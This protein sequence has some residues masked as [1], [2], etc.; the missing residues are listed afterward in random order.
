MADEWKEYFENGLG[1]LKNEI[2]HQFHVI[3]EDV[4]SKVQQVADGVINLDGK[5]DRRADELD[6]KIEE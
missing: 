2:I 6:K 1:D 5:L 4:I 3:S